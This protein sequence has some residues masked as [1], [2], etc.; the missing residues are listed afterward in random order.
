VTYGFAAFTPTAGETFQLALAI[1]GINVPGSVVSFDPSVNVI[2]SVYSFSKVVSLTN[3]A[4][5]DIAIRCTSS[6]NRVITLFAS[7]IVA[8][9]S[10]GA[11]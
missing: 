10:C 6:A 8:R 4:F 2:S 11:L 9:A 1:D 7:S 5:L 3:G